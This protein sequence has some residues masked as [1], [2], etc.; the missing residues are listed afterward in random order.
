MKTGMALSAPVRA[1]IVD[2]EAPARDRLRHLLENA[3]TPQVEIVA[4]ARTGAEAIASILKEDPDLV[5]LNV[6]R[7]GD[8]PFEVVRIIGEEWMPPMIVTTSVREHALRA[9]E[10]NAVD[11]LLKPFTD[12]RFAAA[13]RKA[14]THLIGRR[15]GVPT[16]AAAVAPKCRS[17]FWVR[18]DTRFNPV[19]VEDVAWIESEGNYVRL[20]LRADRGRHLGILLRETLRNI[21]ASLDSAEWIRIHRSRVVRRQLISEIAYLSKGQYE[22]RLVDEVRLTTGRSYHAEMEAFLRGST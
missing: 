5:I 16:K 17:T 21:Q 15:A 14:H 19:L 2:D 3:G 6:Q 4:E 13:L 9:F 11:Y 10:C 12:E 18:K 8:D 22:I 20:H 7:P 1:V